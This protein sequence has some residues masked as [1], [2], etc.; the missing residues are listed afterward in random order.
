METKKGQRNKLSFVF[1]ILFFYMSRLGSKPSA[2]TRVENESTIAK[3]RQT[4]IRFSLF[5]LSIF[6][7]NSIQEHQ[8]PGSIPLQLLHVC[9][10]LHHTQYAAHLRRTK[11]KASQT[12]NKQHSE[13]AFIEVCRIGQETATER[14]STKFP[15]T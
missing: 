1:L 10:N 14:Q 9:C 15:F 12:A 7:F 8:F 2:S 11:E 13:K 6:F 4:E 3:Y 5:F